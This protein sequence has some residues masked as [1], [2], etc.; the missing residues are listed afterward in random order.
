MPCGG[1]FSFKYNAYRQEAL[2]L[3]C[4][5]GI[6]AYVGSLI[7]VGISYYRIWKTETNYVR[8]FKLE[9]YLKL[10]NSLVRYVYTIYWVYDHGLLCL[11]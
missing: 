4:A 9:R 2:L 3:F 7:R 1:Y 8:L 10:F 11:L 5:I 6:A